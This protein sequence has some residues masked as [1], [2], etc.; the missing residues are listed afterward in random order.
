[1]IE[2]KS[3]TESDPEGN[4]EMRADKSEIYSIIEKSR[5]ITRD[6]TDLVRLK[7]IVSDES[8]KE[9]IQIKIQDQVEQLLIWRARLQDIQDNYRTIARGEREL[10]KQFFKEFPIKTESIEE[11]GEKIR[12]GSRKEISKNENIRSDFF[13]EYVYNCAFVAAFRIVIIMSVTL[14]TA[15]LVRSDN[16]NLFLFFAGCFPIYLVLEVTA[17]RISIN[18]FTKSDLYRGI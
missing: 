3:A 4:P 13:H 12:I 11:A 5:S 17:M 1:M 2:N 18:N 6:L 10:I 7:E 9:E 16:E 8:E 14:V 15:L